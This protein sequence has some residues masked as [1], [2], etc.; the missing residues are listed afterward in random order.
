M[1]GGAEFPTFLSVP[2][3]RVTTPG[4]VEPATFLAPD[5]P[6]VFAAGG[7]PAGAQTSADVLAGGETAL[8]FS[9]GVPSDHGPL[10]VGQVFGTRYHI[11]KLLGV[12]GMGAVY[13]AWDEEL[14]VAVAIKVIRPEVMADPVAAADIERRFKRELLLARE[15]THRNVVRIHDLGEIDGIKYITMAYV[16]GADLATLI[17]REGRL[18]PAKAL[19]ISRSVVSGLVAAHTANVVHR[20][21]KP[22]NI[23]VD[24]QDEALIMDFGI[25]RSTAEPVTK[26]AAPDLKRAAAGA[27]RTLS[28]YTDATAVGSIVGTVEY[29]APEQAKGLEVDQ[30]ADVYAF[31]LILYDMLTGRRRAELA[32][33]AFSEL[34]ARMEQAPPPAKSVVPEV[35]EALD[36]LVSRCIEP[37]RQKRFASTAELA[38]ELD[39]LDE[40]GEP[41]P[42][43]RVVGMR[44]MAAIVTVLLGLSVGT[45]WYLHQLIPPAQHEPVSVLIGDFQNG[46]SDPTFDRMLEPMLKLAL[47]GAG[48]ISAYDR[49]GISRNLGVR[50]PEKLDE[51]AA[52]ELAVRQGVGVVLS[53]SVDRQ[54]SGYVVSVKAIQ[55]V[56]GNVISS[57]KNRASSKEQV[58]SAAAKLANVV[59]EALGDDASDSSQL[60]AT[61][62]LSATSL[63]VVRHYAAAMEALSNS[64]FEEAR[65]G[66]SDAV[67][68]DPNFGLGYAGMAVASRNLDKLQDAQKYIKEAIR[69]LDGMTERER[70][71]TRGLAFEWTSDYQAC[72]K[73]FGDLI[74]R[75][76][77]DAMARNNLAV[78]LTYLR[79]LPKAIDEMRQAIKILPKR[80]LYRENLALYAAY[81]TDFQT[82]EQEARAIEKPGLFGLLPLAFAQVLQGQ[83]P[84][85]AE[86]YQSMAKIDQQGASYAASGLGELALY[87]G[88]FSEA[89]RIFT[90]G[91]SA[92]LSAKD[93]DRAATKFA[94]LAYTELLRQQKGAAIAAAEKALATSKAVK[95]RFLAARVFVEAGVTARAHVLAAGL[96]SELQTEPQ[97]YAKIV[98]GEAA[99]KS[100]DA[101][102]AITVLTEANKLFDTW[103]GHFDLGRA[104]LEAGA[105][106]QADS[107]FDRCIKR[108]GETLA[109]FLDEEPTVGYLPPVYYYKGRVRE[110]L[111]SAGFADSY[112]T[113]L[114]IRGQSKEDPLLPE[115]RRLAGS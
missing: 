41:I 78:C 18:P 102:H 110:G 68:L 21:L 38:A 15:V 101:R 62:T 65:R 72:V 66:F 111:K 47:E 59:R 17:R 5:A 56:T 76:S 83:L 37:D 97:A 31:G 26:I 46:T 16:N 8:S 23:M 20:D 115:V 61:E 80:T 104:Y 49:S 52:L 84:Q 44:M 55:A 113:Y 96:G 30:R 22:A 74:E 36:R 95:I 51:R 6:T 107:E 99:L 58:L 92:D 12:G 1:V 29:M 3:D 27:R 114:T 85:A 19:R 71:R 82:A 43:R 60:F 2:E 34:Q 98:E 64:R 109:L 14:A 112:R 100:R 103:M 73:E 108:R 40:N 9:G 91:A 54:G 79:D 63:E 10:N 105:L 32:A 81:S 25:A 13:Q 4:P 42:I 24:A 50:P 53:G 90:E 39:R 35:P 93:T 89:A 94:A 69:H 33:S 7:Q 70:Y 57:A 87:E 11:I 28:K 106:T 75:Y 48:F 77:A 67:A 88:R 45:L 86:T